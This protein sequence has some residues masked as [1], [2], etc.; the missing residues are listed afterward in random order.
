MNETFFK[1]FQF[2][3]SFPLFDLMEFVEFNIWFFKDMLRE[4]LFCVTQFIVKKIVTLLLSFQVINITNKGEFI[5]N[6]F[7]AFLVIFFV[8]N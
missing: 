3:C 7:Y 2:S 4:K 8:M 5:S 1:H 6:F